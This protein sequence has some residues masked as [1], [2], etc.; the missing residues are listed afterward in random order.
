MEKAEKELKNREKGRYLERIEI[1]V[2][3]LKEGS[4]SGSGVGFA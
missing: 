2:Y 3:L 4:F 1:G